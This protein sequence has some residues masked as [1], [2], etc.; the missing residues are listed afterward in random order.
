MG[1][2]IDLIYDAFVAIQSDGSLILD[3]DFMNG[4]FSDLQ[5]EMPEFNTY[6]IW[7]FEEKECSHLLCEDLAIIPPHLCVTCKIGDILR[8]CDKEFNFTANYA[9]GHGGMFHAWMETFR[10]GSLFVPVVQVLNGNQQ[11]TAFEGAFPL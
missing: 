6:M 5:K 7:F 1:R 3:Y 2:V 8:A 11:D 4:I 9:K 10:P